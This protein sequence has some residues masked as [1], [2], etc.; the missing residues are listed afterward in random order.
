MRLKTLFSTA[1]VIGTLAG[2]A[3]PAVWSAVA[4]GHEGGIFAS[5][6]LINVTDMPNAQ[7]QWSE[8]ALAEEVAKLGVTPVRIRASKDD[9]VWQG[10]APV[11]SQSADMPTTD[12]V[13][14]MTLLNQRMATIDV[15][16]IYHPGETV[17]TTYERKGKTI[18]EIKERPGYSTGGYSYDV[19]IA[20]ANFALTRQMPSASGE[21]FTD[22]VWTALAEVQGG[23]RT[24]WPALSE[25]MARRAVRRLGQD[26]VLIIP[27]PNSLKTAQR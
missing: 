23:Q 25:D 18:T 24:G 21:T 27:E 6:V 7:Q 13:L 8:Q 3:D 9:I 15:P 19:P 16:L 26:K 10:E 1:L 12:A 4:P 2:C 5:R 22:T 11:A 14:T 17:V 20:K